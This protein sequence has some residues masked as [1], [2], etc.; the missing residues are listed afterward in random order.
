MLFFTNY[1]KKKA[2]NSY[3]QRLGKDLVK[4]YGKRKKY[5][6]GQVVKAVKKG[7]YNWLYVC[8]AHAMY[9]SFKSFQQWHREQGE[10]CDYHAMKEEVAKNYFDGNALS[11]D[12]VSD[13]SCESSINNDSY[14]ID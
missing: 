1:K 10:T 11:L 5:S 14:D 7:N 6:S 8:Y 13:S 12:A 4:N 9:T 2:I 3:I